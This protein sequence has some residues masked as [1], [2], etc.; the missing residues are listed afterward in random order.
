[1]ID[2]YEINSSTLAILPVSEHVSEIVEQESNYMIPKSSLEIMDESC[3]YFGSSYY[4]REV[5]AKALIGN[6][7]KAPIIVEETRPLIFLPTS[8]P[9]FSECTWI[10][11]KHI[12][13]YERNGDKTIITFQCGRKLELEISIYSLENQILRAIRL[14]NSLRNRISYEK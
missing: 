13:K 11:L 1:M 12:H 4:G 3:R 5:G 14:E 2:Q 9:R 7:Y 6:N 10:S 8:S